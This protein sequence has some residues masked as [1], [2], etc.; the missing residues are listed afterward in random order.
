MAKEYTMPGNRDQKK[1]HVCK[2]NCD[3]CML[4]LACCAIFRQDDHR[5][6]RLS[7]NDGYC[8]RRCTEAGRMYRFGH[9]R[10]R[11]LT[12]N[13]VAQNGKEVKKGR[14]TKRRIVKRKALIA[15]GNLHSRLFQGCGKS[16]SR[17][18]GRQVV[19]LRT[20]HASTFCTSC[21]V[22]YRHLKFIMPRP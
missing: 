10:P 21:A 18:L 15:G 9:Q 3:A 1:V 16:V 8:R 7:Y 5:K 4:R 6:Y 2:K 22:C 13:P 11:A 19:P 14:R 17:K 12:L 20:Q